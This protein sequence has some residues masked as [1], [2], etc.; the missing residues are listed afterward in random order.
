MTE[1][2]PHTRHSILVFLRAPEIG[3]V[4][5]RLA[6][7]LGDETTLSLYKCFVKD[8]LQT[9][10]KTVYQPTLCYHPRRKLSLITQWLGEEY[11]YWPQEGAS[12]GDKMANGFRRAFREGFDRVVILGTNLPDLP[13]H[14]VNTAFDAL[15]THQ[16]VI[17]PSKDGGY[18]LIGFRAHGFLPAIFKNIPWGTDRVFTDTL[19]VF[20][21]KIAS[22]F[23]LPKWQD[24]DEKED[25]EALFKRNEG[26]KAACCTMALLTAHSIF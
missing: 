10:Q 18:Y 12:I 19:A 8:T 22:V 2:Q 17:G 26:G 11:D 1:N 13:H 20:G 16:A 23:L 14:I 6:K 9:L 7:T 3:L 5:T 21:S 4:K 25:L 15:E 24:I